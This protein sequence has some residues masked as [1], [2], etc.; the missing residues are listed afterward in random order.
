MNKSNCN[1]QQPLP[2]GEKNGTSQPHVTGTLSA[3]ISGETL[4]WLLRI[5]KNMKRMAADEEYR[6]EIAKDLS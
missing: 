6:L 3:E 2:S 5:N 1:L 4:A